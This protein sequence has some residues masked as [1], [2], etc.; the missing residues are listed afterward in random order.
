MLKY[1]IVIMIASAVWLIIQLVRVKIMIQRFC[2]DVGVL[3]LLQDLMLDSDDLYNEFENSTF[4]LIVGEYYVE[5]DNFTSA[6]NYLEDYV[7]EVMKEYQKI[8]DWTGH[9][10]LTEH[11]KFLNDINHKIKMWRWRHNAIE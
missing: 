9:Y 10:D 8:I 7:Q 3:K 1:L 4:G 6:V 11:G 5:F 2:V